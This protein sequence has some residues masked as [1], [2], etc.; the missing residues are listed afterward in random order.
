MVWASEDK[1]GYFTNTGQAVRPIL[2]PYAFG[3]NIL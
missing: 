2:F 3:G 1:E